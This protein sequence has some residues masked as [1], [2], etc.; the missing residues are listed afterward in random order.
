MRPGCLADRSLRDVSS[1][2][3]TRRHADIDV[4]VGGGEDGDEVP[5]ALDVIP[6]LR[7]LM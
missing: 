7:D 1:V 6:V 3:A 5:V 4:T 2:D